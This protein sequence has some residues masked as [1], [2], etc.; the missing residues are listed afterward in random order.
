MGGHEDRQRRRVL[1]DAEVLGEGHGQRERVG[2]GR[3][4]GE[5]REREEGE[6]GPEV[7]RR[8][9]PGHRFESHCERAAFPRR[10]LKRE[11][12]PQD[13]PSHRPERDMTERGHRIDEA[14]GRPHE[15]GK[16]EA[17]TEQEAHRRVHI[18][19]QGLQRE[20]NQ[21]ADGR[22]DGGHGGHCRCGRSRRP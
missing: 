21:A 2:V 13:G 17:R 22:A 18:A 12:G 19:G 10:A 1:R 9:A 7:E 20:R 16:V 5:R 11:G 3:L 8:E 6:G 14:Q 4:Q 15:V